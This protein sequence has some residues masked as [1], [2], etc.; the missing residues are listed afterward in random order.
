MADS[1]AICPDSAFLTQVESR[2]RESVSRCYQCRKCTNG[3]PLAFAMDIMPNQVMRMIQLGMTDEDIFIMEN[4][5]VLEFTADSA[6]VV[7][8]VSSGNVFVDG[9]GVGDIGPTVMGEREI[10]ARDGFVI[11]IVPV[12]AATGEVNGRPE[13]ISRGFVYRRESKDLM[14]RAAERVWQGLRAGHSRQR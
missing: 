5:D 10:L 11:A 2:S 1:N 4:G 12:S 3:C 8:H 6:R 9:S 13:L 7:E 14:E